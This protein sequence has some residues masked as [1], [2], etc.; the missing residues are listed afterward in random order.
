MTT[1][2][3]TNARIDVGALADLLDGRWADIRRRT[4]NLALEPRYRRTL[5]LSMAEHRARVREQAQ[6]LA[7]SGEVQRAFPSRLGGADNPGGNIAGFEE[8][9]VADPSLQIKAGVQWGLFGAA[10]L[11]LGTAYHHE[12]FL[13]G[14]MS[15]AVPGCF[16]MTETGHGSD[17]A[18]IGTT[19]TYDAD[20]EEFVIHTPTRS[21]WK[22]YIGN[23][24]VDGVAA[25]VFAQLVTRGVDHG[26]HAF[27]VPLRDTA[28][29]R[30]EHGAYP[31]LPGVGGED[32]GLKGGLLGVDNGRLHF[33]Q[34]RIP[35]RNLLDKYAEVAADGEYSSPIDSP[36]RRF[37]TM[38]GTL[39]QGRVSLGGSSVA[40]SKIALSTAIRY[41]NERR[42][43]TTSDPHTESVILDYGAH[44]RRL[45][46][47]LA[48]TY[49][50]AFLHD[51]LLERFHGV[52][53][54]EHETDADREDLETLAAAS[55][56]LSTWLALDVV[57]TSREACG[58]AGYMAENGLVGLHQDMDVYVTFEGDN[59]VLLQLVGKRLLTDYGREMA[60]M[61]VAGAVRYVAD[62]AGDMALH[63][64]PLRRA[65]Q[66]IRDWGSRARSAEELREPATQRELLEDRVEAMVEVIAGKLRAVQ[67]ASAAEQAAAFNAHQHELI[68]AARAHGELMQWEA[69]TAGIARTSDPTTKQVLT[70]LRDL[71]GLATI[72][73]N[74]AWYLVNGRLSAQRART[75][76]SYIE[77]LLVRLRPHAEDLV[78][79]FGYSAELIGAP[80]GTGAEGERQDEA[81]A[82]Y[83]E[84]R[85]SG[86]EPV[87][88][89]ALRAREKKAARAARAS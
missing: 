10:V 17:V 84:L 25:V 18:S 69:F 19:A 34:V 76:T 30:D 8:L 45:L 87:T 80:I 26:V 32:D 64:T 88:E 60:T 15:M 46:P 67:K 48:R 31:Y 14:I 44:Q 22:E 33:D 51:T 4:R 21:A 61:D 29:E 37:F 53:S 73:K 85:A 6:A 7:D 57:Q 36:G 63:R 47:L 77:R 74:L 38:L 50:A 35:R 83:R 52:F 68:E 40:T 78:D 89:K 11:H 49:A 43:F 27:Y 66:S 24:A 79:A 54:G 16:A 12:E 20:A 65:S 82:Y 41:G 28:G 5:G 39:V 55:K 72:E 81:Q 13:P 3:P 56:A 9:V 42:Q 86:Q 70:W 2:L 1:T 23:A 62:R 75:V 58:G 71:F 59:T